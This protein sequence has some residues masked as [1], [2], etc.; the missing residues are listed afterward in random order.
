MRTGQVAAAA[1]VNLQTLRY[2]ERRGLLAEPERGTSGYR[3]YPSEVVGV[4]RFIKQAQEL[5]FS[6][7]EVEALL[8]LASGGPES[9]DAARELAI[10]KMEDLDRR[11]ASLRGMRTSLQTLVATCARPRA[12]RECPM[13]RSIEETAATREVRP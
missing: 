5:G 2:Y 8:A 1:G 9:C 12:E 10:Q 11:I 13:L 7:S 4:V 3:A 6:L